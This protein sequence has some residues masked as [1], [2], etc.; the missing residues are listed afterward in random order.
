M[1]YSEFTE[2]YGREIPMWA[3]NEVEKVYMF[4]SPE[5]ESKQDFVKRVKRE[6]LVEHI[7]LRQVERLSKVVQEVT[8]CM[9]EGSLA[10]HELQDL[11]EPIFP[12]IHLGKSEYETLA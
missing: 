9:V 3:Y 6:G 5:T 8:D 7:Y 4:A 11:I 10:K 1:L 12:T 2:L